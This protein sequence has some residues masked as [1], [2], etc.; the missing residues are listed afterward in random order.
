MVLGKERMKLIYLVLVFLNPIR[1]VK[2][3][4]ESS[5]EYLQKVMIQ[6]QE[7]NVPPPI[8]IYDRLSS[9]KDYKNVI[10]TNKDRH[11]HEVQRINMNARQNT[12]RY[13]N[14]SFQHQNMLLNEKV[15]VHST[16]LSFPHYHEVN[17]W[18]F[19]CYLFN[20][21][22]VIFLIYFSVSHSYP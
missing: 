20:S 11:N 17:K 13:Q 4:G 22:F 18:Y 2:M 14:Q 21:F 3:N 5:G 9:N 15:D 10:Y 6:L 19:Y 1:N 16:D 8:N 7:F 12:Q